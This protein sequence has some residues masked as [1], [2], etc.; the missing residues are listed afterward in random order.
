MESD[1]S[2]YSL[3]GFEGF[4]NDADDELAHAHA[5]GRDQH[6]AEAL[7]GSRYGK[8]PLPPQL[9]EG[10]HPCDERRCQED[11]NREMHSIGGDVASEGW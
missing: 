5:F 11:V 1:V 4:L 2:H 10:K 6:A 8:C 7:T 3:Y 9:A